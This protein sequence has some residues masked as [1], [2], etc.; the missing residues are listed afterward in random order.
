MLQAQK[1]Q[2][3]DVHCYEY[4]VDLVIVFKVHPY[5]PMMESKEREAEKIIKD[6]K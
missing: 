3:E 2:I 5:N 6:W 4:T 1:E